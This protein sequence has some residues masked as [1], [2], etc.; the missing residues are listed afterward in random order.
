[1]HRALLTLLLL[2]VLANVASAS[3]QPNTGAT[4]LDVTVDPS[5]HYELRTH[6]PEWTF[7][8][9]IGQPVANIRASDGQDGVGAFHQID[10]DY[11][12]RTSGIRVYQQAPLALFMTIYAESGAN[13]DPFPVF[14]SLPKLPYSV[15][16]RDVPFSPY[17]LNSLAD[18]P[19]G[20]WLFLDAS[21]NGF[22]V[23][24][25]SD[26]PVARMTLT[27]D[28]SLRSGID[29]GVASLPA[30]Y[31]Y[32]TMLVVGAGPNHLFDV[33]GSAMTSLH[34]KARPP[35]DADLTLEKFGYW[36][37]NGATYYYH[38]EPQLGYSGTLLGVKRDF[39]QRGIPIGYLQLDSW[40]YPKGPNARW[41]D[42]D[43]GIFRYRA[44]PDLFPDDLPAFQQQVG[45]PLVTHA[46]WIDPSSPY[47]AELG[48]SGN[49][50]TDPRYWSDLMGYLQTG[51]VVTYEQDWL[52]AQAQ[53]V[54]DLS[55]PQ[56]FMG[57]MANAAA[58]RGLTL[59]YCMP[60]PRHVLQTV[61]YGNVTS[62]RVSDDRFD[63]TRWDTFLYTSRLAS[64]L[65]VW[66]WADVFMSTE[67]DNLLL[68][69][70]SAGVV[71][72]GDAIGAEDAGNLR[73]VMRNDAVLVKPDVPLVPTDESILAEA[74]QGP[75]TPMV[76]WTFTDHGSMRGLY[77]FTYSRS[78]A[79][80]DVSFSPASL[81]LQGPVYVYD[82]FADAG[83][84]LAAGDIFTASVST[85]SY[86]LAA[87]VGPT[88]IAFLGDSGQFASLG[89][90]RISQLSDDGTL[91][92]TIEFAP[93][94]Q[95]LTL[96][97]YAPTAP[98]A[99]A[100]GGSVQDVTY[101]PAT[102]RFTLVLRPDAAPSSVQVQLTPSP[103]GRGLG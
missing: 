52:G 23:S 80:Q 58:Q 77:V 99:A 46:R 69:D 30:G 18:A 29:A 86:F 91:H 79:P 89:R 100:A 36:T 2:I 32:Q 55:A 22:L 3:A 20:P 44:A 19:D 8:G 14:S 1:M 33:W 17:Q 102:Q 63:R 61:E 43:H 78:D 98:F 45:L 94:E 65:G 90:K 11:N 39:D 72:T 66:P 68:A 35:N 75:K 56:Q 74:S 37:D 16:F 93:G 26:F 67:R 101:D 25:A 64:A 41:D 53:P 76:A 84:L 40:W 60:L 73:R 59:Q 24:P 62:M 71:G 85:G 92:A 83:R 50:M 81:G 12:Q 97:G 13:A 7:A 21:G 87:P 34:G 15:S 70:L 31:T 5:G 9:D 38:F 96:F 57:N 6:A 82:Y 47:R 49:V 51:G 4:P 28:G 10:F 42:R 88:G 27:S 95:T 48:F 103:S 54:Y